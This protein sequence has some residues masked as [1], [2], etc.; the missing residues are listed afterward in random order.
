MHLCMN[1]YAHMY[2]PAQKGRC[3][4]AQHQIIDKYIY[5]YINIYVYINIYMYIYI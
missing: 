1:T 2:K 5:T 4:T 3:D